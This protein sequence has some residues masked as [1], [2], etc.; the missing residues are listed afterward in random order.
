MFS[1]FK[2]RIANYKISHAFLKYY[3]QLLK[4]RRIKKL[5]YRQ[6]QIKKKG[7]LM[8]IFFIPDILGPPTCLCSKNMACQGVRHNFVGFQV[9][10]LSYSILYTMKQTKNI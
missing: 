1:M 4:S 5:N 9:E 2:V 7:M 10:Q 8:N 6:G 3:F